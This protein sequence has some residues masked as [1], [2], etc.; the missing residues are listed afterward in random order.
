M[1]QSSVMNSQEAF[2]GPSEHVSMLH[3]GN[4]PE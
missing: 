2:I 4:D 3:R 1:G